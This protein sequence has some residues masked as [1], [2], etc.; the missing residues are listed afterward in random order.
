MSNRE[1]LKYN[2]IYDYIRE[3][4]LTGSYGEGDKV[5]TQRQLATYFGVSRPTVARALRELESEGIL[6]C[7]QGAGT[8]IPQ[9][10]YAKIG[11]LGLIAPSSPGQIGR[12][13]DEISQVIQESGYGLLWGTK[14]PE[15][16]ED[17][18]KHS[19]KL[20]ELYRSRDVAGVFFTP[21]S[22]TPE[23]ALINKKIIENIYRSGIQVVLLD[24]DICD[25]PYRSRFDLVVLDNFHAGLIMTR[26]LLDLGYEKIEF[27]TDLL[28]SSS[29]TARIAG[30]KHALNERGI[31]VNAK[32][33]HRLDAKELDAVRQLMNKTH[34]DAL[35]CINDAVAG[36]LMQNFKVLDINVPEDVA[37]TGVDDDEQFRISH[38]VPITTLYQP[39][40]QL[41][42]IAAKM[43]L[44]RIEDPHLPPRKISVLGDL[45]IRESCGSHI[46][47]KVTDS[48]VYSTYREY[49]EILVP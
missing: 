25:F 18:I 41:S 2:Q 42:R 47:K 33:V 4:I 22:E 17:I 27:V 29:I 8:F 48:S 20:C 38:T 1:Q 5:P 26:H 11:L 39:F 34:A 21:L 49:T 16:I 30:Y 31:K 13:A 12:I 43:M 36:R 14:W 28:S 24:R 19:E 40:D 45:V 37:L 23:H 7:R 6:V 15:D 44:E 10:Q 46:R 3:K 9:K 32:W 35:V